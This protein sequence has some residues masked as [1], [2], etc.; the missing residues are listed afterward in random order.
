MIVTPRPLWLLDEPTVSLD[1]ASV[2][3][4]ATLWTQHLASG[5]MVVAATHMPL[6]LASERRLETRRA[7]C[8]RMSAFLTLFEA[9]SAAAVREGGAM[10]T[11]LGFFLVV[12]TLMPLGL[13]PDLNLL[14]RIAPGMLWIALLL[15]GAAVAAA[16]VRGDDE[17][18]SLEV[19]ATGDCRSSW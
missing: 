17:D 10:G 1:A 5:G 12:V 19:I 16:D 15:G 4:L 7:E 14:S 11:A 6:G 13:G 18:G 2:K 9:R 3:L 8:R